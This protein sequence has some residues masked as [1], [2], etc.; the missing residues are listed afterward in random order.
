MWHARPLFDDDIADVVAMVNACEVADSGEVMLEAADIMADLAHADRQRDA[1]VVVQDGRIVAWSLIRDARKR[2]AD[3]HPDARGQGIGGWLLKWAAWRAKHLGADRTGQTIDDRR[4]D[5]AAWLQANGY[6]PRYTSWV[7]SVP[8]APMDHTARPATEP[9]L[10]LNLFE[11]AFSEFSDRAPVTLDRWREMTVHKTGFAAGD[12]LVVHRDGEIAGA[13]FLIDADG[14]WVEK[15]VVAA[16]FRGQGVA[17]EL[18][19]AAQARAAGA[20]YDRV[21]LSTDSNT[22]ALAMYE[23]LGMTVERSFTHWAIDL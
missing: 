20:G 23:H 10:V 6:T 21:R 18:L 16:G 8:S 1:C 4:T 12:L 7:L 5:V 13:A 17:R 22:S 19:A 3:V 9:D 2:W 15:L 14:I 11:T